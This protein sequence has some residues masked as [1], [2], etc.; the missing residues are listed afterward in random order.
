MVQ[1]FLSN[2]VDSY[3]VDVT[4]HVEPRFSRSSSTDILDA[5]DEELC[6]KK[7]ANRFG[8]GEIR[9]ERRRILEPTVHSAKRLTRRH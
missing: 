8:D 4:S 1:V 5:I 9:A 2:R 6:Q 3:S 7:Y